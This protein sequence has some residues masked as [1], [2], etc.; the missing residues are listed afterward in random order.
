MSVFKSNSK[1][2][3][4]NFIDFIFL[5]ALVVLVAVGVWAIVSGSP[6]ATD[7][8]LVV[9]TLEFDG[10]DN[11]VASK[12]QVGDIISNTATK[13]VLGTVE[14]VE[15]KPQSIT[16]L[17]DFERADVDS[18]GEEFTWTEKVV[19]TS[20]SKLYSTVTVTCRVHADVDPHEI[21]INGVRIISGES[22][23]IYSKDFAGV[24]EII[25]IY[26]VAKTEEK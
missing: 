17:V 1:K 22:I 19:T 25:S 18:N 23:G 15:V 4:Y 14:G 8:Q 13:T 11:E 16:E 7:T 26:K 2:F 9:F 20:Q 21:S 6:T 3:K 12:L 10:V 24:G 5:I